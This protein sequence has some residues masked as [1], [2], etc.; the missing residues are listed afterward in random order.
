[1]AY[2]Y[3]TYKYNFK[4]DIEIEEVTYH[5]SEITYLDAVDVEEA[6][7]NGLRA[8]TSKFL[9]FSTGLSEEEI[10]KLSRKA[11]VE[12]QKAVNEVNGL[13]FQQP[14]ENLNDE[15]QK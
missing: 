8:G 13:D 12:L 3:N 1:M 14:A 4:M 9:Q 2:K 15:N 5:V 11:G 7:Q 6:K 10:S